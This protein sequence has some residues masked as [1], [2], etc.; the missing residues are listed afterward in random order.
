MHRSKRF[1]RTA[2]L[3]LTARALFTHQHELVECDMTRDAALPDSPKAPVARKQYLE[4]LAPIAISAALCA[5][6]GGGEQRRPD[7]ASGGRAGS[8]TG[9]SPALA[10][11]SGAPAVGGTLGSGGVAGFGGTPLGGA[12]GSSAV[13]G[14][15]TSGSGASGFNAG[16]GSGG[17]EA[18]NGPGGRSAGEGGLG[19]S[20]AGGSGAGGELFFDDFEDGEFKGPEPLMTWLAADPPNGAW[21][22]SQQSGRLAYVARPETS[23]LMLSAAGDLRWTDQRVEAKVLWLEGDPVI[24]VMGR[25]QGLRTYISLEFTPGK[26]ATDLV[27]DLK[28][29]VRNDGSTTSVCRAAPSPAP[30]G[31]WST[32]GFSAAGGAGSMLTLYFNGAELTAESPCVLPNPAPMSGGVAVGVRDGAAAFDDVRVTRPGNLP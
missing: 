13:A 7:S 21:S 3:C 18:G 10:G 19:G 20:S 29:R 17:S 22:V 24:L 30:R 26:S 32:L 25:F 8:G 5:A 14:A 2:P 27:G 28:V 23:D 11:A 4:R 6:C 1:Y 16:G 9:G 12:A 15:G 31:V